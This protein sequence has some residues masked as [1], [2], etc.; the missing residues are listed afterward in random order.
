MK[1]RRTLL[2][3]TLALTPAPALAGGAAVG[4]YFRVMTRPDLQGGNG[5]LGYWNLYGRLL[6]EG[7]YAALEFRFDVLEPQPGTDQLWTSLHAKI[8]GGS[9]RNADAGD[10]SLDH[11]RLSQVYVLAGNV[12]MDHVTW[13]VGTLETWF[14]DLGL[15]DMRPAGIFNDTVGLSARY[16]TSHLDL[17]LGLGDSGYGLYGSSY[18]TVFTPG[19]TA[20]LKLGKHL[21]LGA[22]G[23]FRYEPGVEGDTASPY[24]TPGVDYEDWVRGEVVQ[25]Y[26]EEYPGLED[27]FPDPEARAST[28][29][30]AIG[31]LGFGGF[32]PVRW[33]NLFLRYEQLHP[34]KSTTETVDGREYTIYVHDLTDQRTQLT[35]GDELQLALVPDRLDLALG[36]LYIDAEDGDNQILPTDYDRTCMSTVGR[37]QIYATP[38]LHVLLEGSAAREQSHNGNAF[39]D[40][41]DSIFAN[42]GGLPDTDGLESGDDDTRV[43][44]QGKGGLV[45][46]PLGPGIYTRPSLRLL[47][48][49]QYSTQNNAFGNSFVESLDQYATFDAVEQHWHHLLALETEIWF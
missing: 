39:R 21:E 4:G 11:L 38:S 2:A 35:V 45:L 1:I 47:Y 15:Y 33:N 23:E 44:F 26:L 32:G 7:P 12:L 17:L 40:H 18:D 3:L 42:T 16:Q 20:R 13:Q 14:G 49:V 43:T 31:Y 28:S 36:G 46:N 37:L 24:Q 22:G 30:V 27:Y 8:E 41:K 9:I 29:G 19:G 25:R 10:G 48:G 5:K 34:D 6:N